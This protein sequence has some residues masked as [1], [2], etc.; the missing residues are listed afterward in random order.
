M[1]GRGRGGLRVESRS[2]VGLEFVQVHAVVCAGVDAPFVRFCLQTNEA[3]AHIQLTSHAYKILHQN[4]DIDVWV[5]DTHTLTNPDRSPQVSRLFHS[6]R[7]ILLIDLSLHF[8]L[9]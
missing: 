9:R 8:H 5:H 2:V 6:T 4:E 1:C 3:H 7:A